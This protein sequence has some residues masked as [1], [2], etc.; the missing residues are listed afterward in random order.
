M[1]SAEH[2]EMPQAHVNAPVATVVTGTEKPEGSEEKFED[3][4][5]KEFPLPPLNPTQPLPRL[6]PLKDVM[7][8]ASEDAA[9]AE[10]A[11]VEAKD[12]AAAAASSKQGDGEGESKSPRGGMS[13]DQ[14]MDLHKAAELSAAKRRKL[15]AEE[16]SDTGMPD[17][18]LIVQLIRLCQSSLEYTSRQSKSLAE[19]QSQLGETS[20]LAFHSESCA[21]YCLSAIN[22]ASGN[23][24]SVSWQ[25]SGGRQSEH[26]SCK[27]LLQSMSG[28]LTNVEKSLNQMVAAINKQTSQA[29]DQQKQLS[30]AIVGMQAQI[31]DAFAKLASGVPGVASGVQGAPTAVGGMTL[32]TPMGTLPVTSIGAPAF[33][34]SAMSTSQVPPP[35]PQAPS[36]MPVA[37][38]RA[39]IMIQVRSPDGQAIQRAASPTRY[40]DDVY[41]SHPSFLWCDD[42]CY[43]RLV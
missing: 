30:D 29:A 20:Q 28:S 38:G 25:L 41:R 36:P 23:L 14:A 4:L 13:V 34:A 33:G 11:Y 31:A 2:G 16:V 35:P 1:G 42:G 26:Q 3:P 8:R 39:P 37:P 22:Q 6:E 21:R 24:K 32:T 7:Q 15:T 43:R 9:A 40:V 5:K 17:S 27:S 18:D 10:A 19:I 12:A